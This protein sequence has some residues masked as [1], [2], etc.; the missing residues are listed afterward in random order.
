MRVKVAE[1][2]SNGS[3]PRGVSVFTPTS[4]E[5]KGNDMS[6]EKESNE[7][8]CPECHGKASLSPCFVCG[9]PAGRIRRILRAQCPY[10]QGKGVI[11]EC[12]ACARR[13]QV[14]QET[15][16]EDMK[17]LKKNP[18]LP[19]YDPKFKKYRH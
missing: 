4:I 18:F 1:Q 7:V 16:R 6:L 14:A 9:S 11:I 10:C 13:K 17:S 12:K 3:L 5:M 2:V 19:Y 15:L 8:I